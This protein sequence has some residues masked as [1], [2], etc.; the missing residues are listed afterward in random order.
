MSVLQLVNEA[1]VFFPDLKVKY[2]DQSPLMKILGKVLFF[3][4]DFMSVYVTT[5]GSTVYFPSE[6]FIKIR[7]VSGSILFLHELVHVYDSKKIS[8]PLFTF[9]Y[10]FP[11]ILFLLVPL[12]F[13][14]SWMLAVPLMILFALPLPA[15]FRMY[16][17]KR[18][19]MTSLY[20]RSELS[21]RFAFKP[22]LEINKDFYLSEFKKSYYYYMWVFKDLDKEFDKALENINM[23]KRPFEDPI[24]DVLDKLVLKV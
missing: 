22:E 21:K 18:A 8:R 23:G 11:Q 5:V 14:V 4:K 3:N 15:Y 2:K 13:F 16:Y 12:L 19:Y 9:L 10:L 24:F 1:Q 7:P 20:V 6:N 17:E